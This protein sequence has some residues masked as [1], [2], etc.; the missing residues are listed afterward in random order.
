MR[1][2]ITG[3][4]ASGK[5]VL[6]KRLEANGFIYAKPYTTRPKREGETDADYTFISDDEFAYM[7]S[8][9]LF[10]VNGEYNG[11]RYGITM[12]DYMGSNLAV[13]TPEYIVMLKQMGLMENCFTILLMPD[14]KVRWKRLWERHD[15]DSADRRI[16]ADRQQF[17]DFTCYDVIITNPYF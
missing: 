9:P 16:E 4:A 12:S 13:L 11:W 6:R 10:V 1:I 15:A 7:S 3:P 2:I 5:D 17:K 8:I 14:E